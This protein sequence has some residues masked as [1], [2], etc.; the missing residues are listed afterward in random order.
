M[1]F[2]TK[3]KLFKIA[4]MMRF[5]AKFLLI[6]FLA[7]SCSPNIKNN[8]S[9]YQ[10][11]FLPKTNFM[12]S[13]KELKKK[14]AKVVIFALD[15]NDIKVAKDA[16]LGINI[17][18]NIENIIATN[19]L[20][21]IIDRSANKKLEQEIALNE[22]KNNKIY[23][24]P[25]VADYAI[26][27]SIS[28]ASFSSKYRNGYTYIN[29]RNYQLVTIPAQYQYFSKV[30][31]NIKIYELPSLSAIAVINFNGL[32]SRNENAKRNGGV[33]LGGIQIGGKTESGITRDDGLI[34]SAAN[35]SINKLKIKLQNIF[36]KTGYILEKR[37]F[38]NKIIFKISIGESDGVK[39][40]DKVAISSKVE[41][42]N[43]ITEEIEIETQQIANGYVSNKID[44]KTSWIIVKN[45]DNANKIRL[46]DKI[47]LKY[48][49]SF[50]AKLFN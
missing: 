36:A 10:K 28:D 37:Q 30:S 35:K 13:K 50:F 23:Q 5:S 43:P 1:I 16:K 38:K 34:R 29:P 26:S 46:G 4:T 32:D 41:N 42:Q 49:P 39:K 12:P 45:K 22:L 25:K 2:C 21:E 3:N 27:G 44:Q 20:G 8:F 48:K 17:A 47:K 33:S 15:D 40:G 11:Q 6:I 24:G 9:K 14:Q 7:Q 19:K 18:N 31:G